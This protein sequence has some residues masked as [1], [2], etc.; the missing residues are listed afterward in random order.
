MSSN[1]FLDSNE[2]NPY[3]GWSQDQ[4]RQKQSELDKR[5][6]QLEYQERIISDQRADIEIDHPANWPKCRPII[7]HDIRVDIPEHGRSLVTR[8]YFSW[9]FSIVCL[10]LNVVAL[11]AGVIVDSGM[12]T[13]FGI[14]IALLLLGLLIPFIFWYRPLYKAVRNDSG[15]NFFFFFFC[16]AWHILL[17]IIYAIGIPNSGGGGFIVATQ[18]FKVSIGAG[19]ILI[20][21]G[22]FWAFLSAFCILQFIFALRFYKNR[23]HTVTGDAS[24]IAT[25]AATSETGRAVIAQG[26][27]TAATTAASQYS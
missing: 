7:Y 27:K 2:P 3:T 21:S 22:G 20:I 25:D 23:G 6:H 15:L 26:A 1:P 17:A 19:V 8:V 24:K 11:L 5:E 16:Y 10:S 12:A 14:S 9:L 4:L 18:I 13:S